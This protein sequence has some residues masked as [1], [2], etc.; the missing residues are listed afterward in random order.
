MIRIT[1]VTQY[2]RVVLCNLYIIYFTLSSLESH[3][4]V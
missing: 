1:V 4:T 3:T 2:I